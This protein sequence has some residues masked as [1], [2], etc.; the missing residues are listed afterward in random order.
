M[1]HFGASQ[2]RSHSIGAF[3]SHIVF[4]RVNPALILSTP[5]SRFRASQTRSHSI[6]AYLQHIVLSESNPLLFVKFYILHNS[7]TRPR[8]YS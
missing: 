8:W 7:L 4:E 5:L 3:I 6:D 1:H 2:Y